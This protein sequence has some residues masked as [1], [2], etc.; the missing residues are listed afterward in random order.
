MRKPL[1]RLKITLWALIG[2]TA[3]AASGAV[4]AFALVDHANGPVDS[5]E[6]PTIARPQ[7]VEGL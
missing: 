5:I 3:L 2:A 6:R 7:F 4:G 1:S